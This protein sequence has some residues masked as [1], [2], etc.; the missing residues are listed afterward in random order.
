MSSAY[1]HHRLDDEYGECDE[2]DEVGPVEILPPQEML[3]IFEGINVAGM[4][5][6]TILYLQVLTVIQH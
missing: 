2:D 3:S 5:M 6:P 4:I 1:V